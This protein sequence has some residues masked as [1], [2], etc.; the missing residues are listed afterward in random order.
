MACNW[1]I[2]TNSMKV[3]KGTTNDNDIGLVAGYGMVQEII[4]HRPTHSSEPLEI[5]YICF[6]WPI[7]NHE[8]CKFSSPE[9][10]CEPEI[11]DWVEGP[12]YYATEMER[13]APAT[14]GRATLCGRA[15]LTIEL[16]SGSTI[17][18]KF[19]S[20]ASLGLA[21]QFSRGGSA[22]LMSPSRTEETVVQYFLINL[23]RGF[24]DDVAWWAISWTSELLFLISQLST[25]IVRLSL[26]AGFT[27]MLWL[28]LEYN[29]R[30]IRW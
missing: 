19:Y 26:I 29:Y 10:E 22:P 3:S 30:W 6:I 1:P 14:R 9:L 12:R 18:K 25:E 13:L 28:L 11:S 23:N 24:K 8:L 2:N 16:L 4:Y 20:V 7:R 15:R 5:L 21:S 17:N 27:Y